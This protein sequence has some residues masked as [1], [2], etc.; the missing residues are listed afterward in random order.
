M[1]A[2]LQPHHGPQNQSCL[3]TCLEALWIG[4]KGVQGLG[5]FPPSFGEG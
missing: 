2:S 1:L 4:G 5:S 3:G